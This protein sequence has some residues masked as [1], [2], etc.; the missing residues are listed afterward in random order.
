M[1]EGDYRAVLKA[2]CA[3]Q[4]PTEPRNPADM[5]SLLEFGT[6][7]VHTVAPRVPEP[8]PQWD[9]RLRLIDF[10]LPSPPA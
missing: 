6:P 7:A 2:L 5:A 1:L 4:P 8:P 9:A 3:D 10:E